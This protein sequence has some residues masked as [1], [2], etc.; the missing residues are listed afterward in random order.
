EELIRSLHMLHDA[1]V[2]AFRQLRPDPACQEAFLSQDNSIQI[3][4]NHYVLRRPVHVYGIR[5]KYAYGNDTLRPVRLTAFW[6]VAGDVSS[7]AMTWKMEQQVLEQS[8]EHSLLVWINQR[9]S[10]FWFSPDER[11]ST[12]RILDV[13]LLAA[14]SP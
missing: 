6:K 2:G 12:C 13:R 7:A 14:E 5:L 8:D 11:P 9:V 4:E 3:G 1:G 10:E